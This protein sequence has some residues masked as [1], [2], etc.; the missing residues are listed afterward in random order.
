MSRTTYKERNNMPEGNTNGTSENDEHRTPRNWKRIGKIGTGL[1]TIIAVLA[2]ISWLR[3]P[4]LS[5]ITNHWLV[6]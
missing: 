1:V 2:L 5:W 3:D 6:T 4:I